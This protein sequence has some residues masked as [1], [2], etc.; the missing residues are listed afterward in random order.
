M[1]Y[2]EKDKH[3]GKTP[4]P[5]KVDSCYEMRFYRDGIANSTFA[6]V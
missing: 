3:F 5:V 2:S 4:L 6:K 1:A